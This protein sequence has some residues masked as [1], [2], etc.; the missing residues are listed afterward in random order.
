MAPEGAGPGAAP[1]W[2]GGSIYQI[3]PRSFADAGGDGI[4]DLDGVIE[5]LDHLEWLGVDGIW[6]SP[7]TVSPDADFGYDVADYCDVD[8]EY[9]TL[10]D[11][12]TL[13][14]ECAARGMRVLLDLVP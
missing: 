1:W 6:L 11:L 10:A 4:G 12:D 2:R 7:V 8:P 9:G 5:H 14:A 3:Y 13:V